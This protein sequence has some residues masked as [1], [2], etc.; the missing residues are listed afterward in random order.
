MTRWMI[1]GAAVFAAIFVAA[2]FVVR[3]PPEPRALQFGAAVSVFAFYV[4]LVVCTRLDR[5]PA[6]GLLLQTTLGVLAAVAIAA[7][8]GFS[9]GAVGAAALLGLILGFTAD[10]W[11]KHVQ[12]P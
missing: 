9:A 5:K 7:V 4:G 2:A 1:L 3:P 10:I 8:L 12:L 6:M 11:V